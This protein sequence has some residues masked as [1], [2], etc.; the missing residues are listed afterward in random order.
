MRMY[1]DVP[2]RYGRVNK[3][4]RPPAPGVG[5]CRLGKE[6]HDGPVRDLRRNGWA[7]AD[8][9]EAAGERS[10]AEGDKPD[11][12]VRWIRSYVLAEESGDVGTV[13]V[14][15]AESPRP[16]APTR[17]QLTCRWTRSFRSP[18]RS[19]CARTHPRRILIGV[20][21]RPPTAAG[22]AMPGLSSAHGLTPRARG[23]PNPSRSASRAPSTRR[24]S[25]SGSLVLLAGEAGVGKTSPRRGPWPQPATAPCS[26]GTR[27]TS[28]PDPYAPIVAALRS[29]LRE[30]PLASQG[31][32][33]FLP[34][35]PLLLPELGEPAPAATRPPWRRRVRSALAQLAGDDHALLVLDDLQWSDEATLELLPALAAPLGEMP[36]LVIAAYR[37][38]GLPRDHMLRHV[39]HELRRGGHLEEIRLAPLEPAETADLLVELLGERP[40]PSLSAAIQDRTQGVPFFVEEL[41]RALDLTGSLTPGRG[42]LR[43]RRERQVPMPETVRDAVMIGTADLSAEARSA[44]EACAVAGETFDLDLVGEVSRPRRSRRA[45]RSRAGRGDR[46][47]NG[48]FRHALTREALYAEVPWLRRRALHRELAGGLE[49]RNARSIE[50]ANHWLG[51]R[52]EA[53]ARDAL[54]RAADESRA[55]EA[56]RDAARA[57]RQAL[58]LWPEGEDADAGSRR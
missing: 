8:D 50:I 29:G 2:T 44:S 58:E 3:E 23:A 47:G 35:W 32:V 24:S 46:D 41:A 7:T 15:E 57:G 40:A 52:D 6:G 53:R 19:S 12:G 51:A 36:L 11:S 37:S 31:A 14:Y 55:V 26:P 42:G 18:T 49:S 27:A 10:A 45:R 22:G 33:R 28:A 17:R 20:R 39:R 25:V 48:A 54:L 43:A 34:T 30:T 9:L 4:L 1:G 38:D 16:S 56:H 21:R 13:C 5:S